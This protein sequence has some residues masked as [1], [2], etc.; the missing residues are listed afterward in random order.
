MLIL[1]EQSRVKP[2]G[3][4]STFTICFTG[5]ASTSGQGDD[6]PA[7]PAEP[8]I[9]SGS[10][11]STWE[12]GGIDFS[13]AFPIADEPDDDESPVPVVPGGP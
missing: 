3:N 4:D 6:P 13:I 8:G 9:A 11:A 12:T 1:E 5:R 2:H 7:D 10:L